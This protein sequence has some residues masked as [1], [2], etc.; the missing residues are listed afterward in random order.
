MAIDEFASAL[1][2][3]L[4][5]NRF[6]VQ[7]AL[8][9]GVGGVDLNV[10]NTLVKAVQLP[11]AEGGDIIVPRQGEQIHLA[12]DLKF[13][14]PW[15]ITVLADRNKFLIRQVLDEWFALAYPGNGQYGRPEDYKVDGTRVAMLDHENNVVKEYK[16]FGMFVSNIPPVDLGDENEDVL[17]EIP[18]ELTFDR[19]EVL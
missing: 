11:G 3:G 10:L 6:R 14:S 8:P 5:Q 9:A 16:F 18:A 1:Q 4:R 13:T 17:V 15:S 19:W 2:G 7:M 12:G